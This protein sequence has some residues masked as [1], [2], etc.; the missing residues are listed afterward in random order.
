M[1]SQTYKFPTKTLARFAVSEMKKA[2]IT[3]VSES[4]LYV[5]VSGLLSDKAETMFVKQNRGRLVATTAETEEDTMSV[6]GASETVSEA[7]MFPRFKKGKKLNEQGHQVTEALNKALE[8]IEG[9]MMD[10]LSKREAY[11]MWSKTSGLANELKQQVGH[12]IGLDEVAPPM[13]KKADAPAAK[14]DK[15]IES[16]AMTALKSKVESDPKKFPKLA[17]ALGVGNKGAKKESVNEEFYGM[18]DSLPKFI[19][20]KHVYHM[21]FARV[22]NAHGVWKFDQKKAESALESVFAD[23]MQ[24]KG[25]KI[26]DTGDLLDEALVRYTRSVFK[27]S[28]QLDEAGIKDKIMSLL[29]TPNIA[30]KFKDAVA[31]KNTVAFDAKVSLLVADVISALHKASAM[32]MAVV[33]F[34]DKTKAEKTLQELIKKVASS[35]AGVAAA[36]H[37]AHAVSSLVMGYEPEGEMLAEADRVDYKYINGKLHKSIDRGSWKP[38]PRKMDF[39]KVGSTTYYRIDKANW[40]PLRKGMT[41]TESLDEG[42]RM[43]DWERMSKQHKSPTPVRVIT[44]DREVYDGRLQKIHKYDLGYATKGYYIVL[45]PS[46]QG[47]PRTVIDDVEVMN[48]YFGDEAIRQRANDKT[49]KSQKSKLPAPP[50]AESVEVDEVAPPSGVGRKIAKKQSSKLAFS[51]TYGPEKGKQVRYATAWKAYNKGK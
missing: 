12:Q 42:F 34:L 10:G 30:K 45:H 48:I 44:K 29:T 33:T 6:L 25:L 24:K 36:N 20:A 51:K 43:Q 13:K 8:K 9:Y 32:T 40:M 39:K 11:R 31:A 18:A 23:S 1:V 38:E 47:M 28:V 15:G 26:R 4:N 7:K 19:P 5:E 49:V 37:L 17:A 2:G 21:F 22:R 3:I 16:A 46:K 41:F 27:E 14:S 50:R 35:D